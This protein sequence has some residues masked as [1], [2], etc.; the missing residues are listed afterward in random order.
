MPADELKNVSGE[1]LGLLT[2]DRVSGL[3]QHDE[4]DAGDMRIVLGP[5]Y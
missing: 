5:V 2:V 4:L 1:G 3:G